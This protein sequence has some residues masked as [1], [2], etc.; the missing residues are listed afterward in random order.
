MKN[1]S[2]L[3]YIEISEKNLIHNIKQFRSVI[4]KNT[5]LSVVV[6]GNAYGHGDKE[7]VSIASPYIDYFQVNSIEELKR[8]KKKTKKPILVFGYLDE[9]GIKEAIKLNAIITSFDFLHLLKINTIAN[10]LKIKVKVHIAIDSYLGREGIMPS[11]LEKMIIELKKMPYI[12]LDGFYSHFANIED[13]EDFSHAQKQI[14]TYQKCVEIFK[15]C[16]YKLGNN[17]GEINTHISATSGIL[18]YEKNYNLQ[19]IVRLGMGLYGLWPS[20]HLKSLNEKKL[21]L[22]PVLRWV[23][24]IAQVKTLPKDYPV[25][26]GLTYITKKKTKIAVIPQGYSD[27]FSRKLSNNGSV[28]IHGKKVDIIGRVAMNMFVVDVSSIKE[29]WPGDEVVLLGKEGNSEITAEEI[30]KEMNSI[31]YEVIA[32]ISPLIPRVII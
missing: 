19:S 4:H 27:G 23:T 15:S 20:S 6:K 14:D 8:I 26:Y 12:T 28:L 11:Q 7:I 25:G 24:H 31:N 3:S 9:D 30:A 5:K 2:P 10:S 17:K 18:M 13:T 16:G 32:K 21:K 22:K 1:K 29:V